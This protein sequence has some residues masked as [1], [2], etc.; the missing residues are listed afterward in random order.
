M[1]GEAALPSHEMVANKAASKKKVSQHCAGEGEGATRKALNVLTSTGT[2]D[3]RDPHV[4]GI[5]QGLHPRSPIPDG[6]SFPATVDPCLG[7]AGE[8]GFWEHLVRE[9]IQRFPRASA[10]G[11]SG[12][13]PSHLQDSLRR[14]GRGG[15]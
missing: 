5:L 15:A 12:L 10:A 14:P 1:E 8:P 6:S 11:P 4:L 7:D 13:R 3:P 2:H 9:G